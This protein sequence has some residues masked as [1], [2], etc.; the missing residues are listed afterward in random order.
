M[1][2]KQAKKIIKKWSEWKIVIYI[3]IYIYRYIFSLPGFTA[4]SI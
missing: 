2:G 4:A 1:E 3:Y